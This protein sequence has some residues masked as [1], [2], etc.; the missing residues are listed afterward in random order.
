M[1]QTMIVFTNNNNVYEL[2]FLMGMNVYMSDGDDV[3]RLLACGVDVLVTPTSARF[4]TNVLPFFNAMF[5]DVFIHSRDLYFVRAVRWVKTHYVSNHT[6]FGMCQP[7]GYET[8][9]CTYTD[10]GDKRRMVSSFPL[11]VLYH[12]TTN[13]KITWDMYTNACIR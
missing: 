6:V 4:K 3:K 10:G 12:M 9:R 5:G 8:R 1:A 13:N 7:H 11:G 2:V